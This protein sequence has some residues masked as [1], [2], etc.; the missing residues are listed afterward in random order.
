MTIETLAAAVSGGLSI[1]ALVL[2]WDVWRE[3]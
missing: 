1:V 2:L 3:L